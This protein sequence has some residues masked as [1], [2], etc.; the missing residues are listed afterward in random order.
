MAGCE[1]FYQNRVYASHGNSYIYSIVECERIDVDRLHSMAVKLA[2]FT[3]EW[4]R[5]DSNVKFAQ[6]LIEEV[7]QER[8]EE[9][10]TTGCND[11]SA[12]K[13][14]INSD[15]AKMVIFLD[16]RFLGGTFFAKSTAHMIGADQI[17]F[18]DVTEVP[19]WK[20]LV[21]LLRFL[22]GGLSLYFMTPSVMLTDNPLRRIQWKTTI[23]KDF[24]PKRAFV[25]HANLQEI[26]ARLP[27]NVHTLNTMVP[28]AFCHVPGIY[29]NIGVLLLSLSRWDTVTTINTKIQSSGYQ[30][31]ATNIISNS[32][33]SSSRGG[34]IRSKIDMIMTMFYAKN[35]RIKV[36]D[37]LVSYM[38]KPD[39]PLYCMSITCDNVAMTT[40]TINTDMIHGSPGPALAPGQAPASARSLSSFG[41][42]DY[43]P[44]PSPTGSFCGAS[45]TFG[46][47]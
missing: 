32:G 41:S 8:F 37:V 33:W 19:L 34:D 20:K 47:T 43:N 14:Y 7:T 27:R 42:F 40:L 3:R 45:P 15:N 10:T 5:G 22:L 30:A 1:D 23:P 2:G 39:Y 12:L 13:I 28:V 26:F 36:K 16:H 25:V 21:S 46:M 6:K 9:L 31:I 4:F 18:P 24:H 17:K 35:C 38:N 44:A 11:D 29:N